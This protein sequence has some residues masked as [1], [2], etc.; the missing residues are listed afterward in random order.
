MEV[1]D[2]ESI[3]RMV[4]V[5]RIKVGKDGFVHCNCFFAAYADEHASHY[6]SKP[7]MWIGI[8]GGTSL[9]ECWTCGSNAKAGTKQSFVDAVERLNSLSGGR[10]NEAVKKALS[11]E[12]ST[13]RKKIRPL[14]LPLD[15][16][17]D[18]TARFLKPA[19]PREWLSAK[20]IEKSETLEKFRVGVDVKEGLVLFPMIN[21]A[22]LVVGAI[23]RSVT[24]ESQ[25]GKYWS[26]YEH[27]QKTHHLFGEHL[28]DIE[29][30]HNK[31][32]PTVAE[33][34]GKALV[35]FE[36]PLDC[37]H[38]S[39]VGLRNCV[40]IMGAKVSPTQAEMLAKWAG[41]KPIA[42]VLDADKA[43]RAGTHKSLNQVFL[44]H[45]PTALVM[46]YSPPVDPKVMTRKQFDELLNGSEVWRRRPVKDLLDE[47]ERAGKGRKRKSR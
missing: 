46:A 45:A 36:G 29:V 25:A 26:V 6:D 16:T 12:K 17:A 2:V 11:C 18:Y 28:L 35:V 27:T 30:T 43:G 3:L 32:G 41:D 19:L 42:L 33:F 44:D 9:C 47:M 1:E 10:Y 39:E 14:Y 40:A 37:M 24:R 15:H 31:G 8:D 7:S 38:A 23:A 22:G 34:K 21:R 13:G 5:K 20:G 4:G